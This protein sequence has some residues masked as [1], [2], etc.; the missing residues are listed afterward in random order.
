MY[1][2]FTSVCENVYFRVYF[3]H[4]LL[5]YI[6]YTNFVLKMLQ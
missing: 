2:Y 4:E 5:L 3:I 1:S 6:R